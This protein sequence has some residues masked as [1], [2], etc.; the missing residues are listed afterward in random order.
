M[1]ECESILRVTEYVVGKKM[2]SFIDGEIV[3]RE[4]EAGDSAFVIKR[5]RVALSKDTR[6]GSVEIDVL[7][8][9][10]FFGEIGVLNGGQRTLTAV[11]VGDLSVEVVGQKGFKDNANDTQKTSSRALPSTEIPTHSNDTENAASTTWFSRL[12]SWQQ[13]DTPHIEVRIVAL[14]GEKGDRHARN[15]YDTLARR[16][17]LNVRVVSG[18]GALIQKT[19]SKN[20]IIEC[21]RDG[22]NL[23]RKSGGDI[24]VWGDV[25][26]DQTVLHLHFTSSVPPDE[27]LPGSMTVFDTLPLPATISSEWGAFLHVMVMSA[28]VPFNAGKAKILKTHMETALEEGAP[29][30]QN[31]PRDFS[32]MDRALLIN[33]LAH[34]GAG[35]PCG[36]LGLHRLAGP[37]CGPRIHSAPTRLCTVLQ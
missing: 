25:S 7:E 2:R 12:F 22:R 23:L 1:R 21:A 5:G 24:L 16:E 29:V 13:R 31:P 18:E 27:D 28:T 17:G 34:P 30:A 8:K 20:V 33:C 3:F 6:R 37:L 4:G 14:F 26:A 10:A 36:L 35:I 9:G 19:V 15:L 11:A 32:P